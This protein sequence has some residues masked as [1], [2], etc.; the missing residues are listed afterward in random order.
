MLPDIAPIAHKTWIQRYGLVIL[1]TLMALGVTLLVRNISQRNL[2]MPFV[3][4]VAI[5]A[6]YGGLNAGIFATGLSIILMN[7]LIIDILNMQGNGVVDVIVMLIFLFLSVFISWL[8][9]TRIRSGK[10]A[11]QTANQLNMVLSGIA[12]AVTAQDITGKPIFSNEV[13]SKLLN[14]PSVDVFKNTPI[15]EIRKTFAVYDENSHLIPVLNLP[16]MKAILNGVSNEMTFRMH[17]FATKEDKWIHMHSSPVYDENG[18]AYLAINVFR[19]VTQEWRKLLEDQAI[20]DNAVALRESSNYLNGTLELEEVLNRIVASATKIVKHD[21]ANLMLLDNQRVRVARMRGYAVA[22]AEYWSIALE[23]AT[24][25]H[26]MAQTLKPIIHPNI[27]TD[28]Y[29]RDLPERERD[30]KSYLGIVISVQKRVIAFLN[31]FSS[32]E[33]AFSQQDAEHL[34]LF[35]NQ[36]ATALQNATVYQQAKEIASLEERQ[37]LAREL[38]DSV[39]QTLFTSNVMAESALRQWQRNPKKAE[40]LVEQVH[41]LTGSAL[42]EMRVLLLELRPK[43]L[44]QVPFDEL[45]RLFVTSVRSRRQMSLDLKVGVVPLLPTSVKIAFYRILQ[46]AINN[47]MKHAQPKNILVEFL[48]KDGSVMLS[49]EDDGAGF[50]VADVG[51]TSLGLGIMRERAEAI[52]GTFSIESE[53]GKGT[54][55]CVTWALT[56]EIITDESESE[57]NHER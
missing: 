48:S 47:I 4:A 57:K 50:S 55:V 17:F 12:D 40:N 27:Q 33:N 25:L 44:E 52:N 15:Q 21:I 18:K 39:S 3:G 5:S 54:K 20:R 11:K 13:A 46:E 10:R 28:N 24:P 51:A 34:Q 41:H 1:L 26:Q 14:F 7:F 22:G 35:A 32:Q 31:I 43:T 16:A 38:H 53:I 6:W 2:Y 49:I 23:D 56:N 45:L 42:A 8:E 37:R 30:M 9:E 36:A 29:W 19:D